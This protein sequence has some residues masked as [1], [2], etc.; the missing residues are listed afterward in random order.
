MP[1]WLPWKR[2]RRLQLTDADL[3]ILAAWVHNVP[4]EEITDEIA[5]LSDL[6][7]AFWARPRMQALVGRYRSE[8]PA[9]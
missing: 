2:E 5:D 7:E 9:S 8:R 3:L 6:E 4:P 1:W